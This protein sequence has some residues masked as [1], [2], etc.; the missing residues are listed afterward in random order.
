[1][2]FRNRLWC[3]LPL[4]GDQLSQ[5]WIPGFFGALNFYMPHPCAFTIQQPF[6][7][8][9]TRAEEE[10]EVHIA[11]LLR[12]D[13]TNSVKRR[14]VHGLSNRVMINKLIRPRHVRSRDQCASDRLEIG[15]RIFKIPFNNWVFAH[16]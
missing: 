15:R 3:F 11:F 16:E 1:M 9:K 10:A 8:R 12:G 14:I 13:V 5:R 6:W 2:D 4:R 7:D